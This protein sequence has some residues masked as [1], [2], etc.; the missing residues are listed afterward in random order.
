[1]KLTA[2]A[3]I[4]SLL[5]ASALAED[6]PIYQPKEDPNRFSAGGMFLF[7]A[8]LRYMALPSGAPGV[9]PGTTARPTRHTYDNGFVDV[10]SS[11]NN[12]P[13]GATSYWGYNSASQWI[14]YDPLVGVAADGF[15]DSI[16]MSAATVA[17]TS[18]YVPG[19]TA[20][21]Q[22][23]FELGYGRVLGHSERAN[24]GAEILLGF[25]NLDQSS[26]GPG[27]LGVT[28]TTDVYSL[29]VNGILV[30]PPAAP[31]PGSQVA[32]PGSPLLDDT[33]QRQPAAASAGTVTGSRSF[34][35]NIYT[36]RLG[37]F[38]DYAATKRFNVGVAAGL[39]LVFVDGR[40]AFNEMI[41]Y[42][43]LSGPAMLVQS[44]SSSEFNTL[45]GGY[46]G[47]KMSYDFNP[48]W[49]LFGTANY[50]G[51]TSLEQTAAGA[52][53]VTLDFSKSILVTLG[54]GYAF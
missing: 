6:A 33:P 12:N 25:L 53:Q 17:G 9:N 34:D 42:T 51:T 37:G 30:S 41:S 3:A 5:G 26:S 39:A 18:G 46:A 20:D 50:L 11:G 8:K 7:N 23:G 10:D 1:M 19:G 21:T 45:V 54:L 29:L 15:R 24:W 22:F 2:S 49:R 4:A 32:L 43:G 35:A 48:R 27:S 47:V 16:S 31:Y 52:R 38:Y 28:T 13:P 40:F 36:L 44:G 14:D